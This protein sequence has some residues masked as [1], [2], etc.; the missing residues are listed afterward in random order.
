MAPGF[1]GPV[2]QPSHSL[3]S[4]T[5]G[6]ELGSTKPSIV[7]QSSLVTT[8]AKDADKRSQTSPDYH[9][10]ALDRVQFSSMDSLLTAIRRMH[11]LVMYLSIN[12]SN[13][14]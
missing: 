2:S 7:T 11:T 1:L 10:G 4:A 9:P 14:F 6:I 8:V 13:D 5:P 3:G 12:T